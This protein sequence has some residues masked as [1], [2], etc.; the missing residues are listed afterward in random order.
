[1]KK[2]ILSYSA[3]E[4]NVYEVVA[5]RGYSVSE[6]VPGGIGSTLPGFG[7]EEDELVY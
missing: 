3:P 2:I 6:P 7:S 5:E 4:V 1:M